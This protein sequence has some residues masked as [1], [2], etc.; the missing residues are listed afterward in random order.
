[1]AF[2]PYSGKPYMLVGIAVYVYSAQPEGTYLNLGTTEGGSEI[3]GNIPLDSIGWKYF[4]FNRVEVAADGYLYASCF[5]SGGNAYDVPENAFRIYYVVITNYANC[6]GLHLDT[7]GYARI[8]QCDFVGNG[9]SDGVHITGYSVSTLNWLIANC[10]I[11][12]LDTTNQYAIKASAAITDAP[13]YNCV[14][15]GNLLNVTPA[16]GTA[17]GSN[18]QV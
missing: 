17:V 15:V 5:D 9:A 12:T 18:V 11:E 14:I 3:A 10:T 13:V 2:Q 7:K 6:R 1:M 16:S 8:N 4:E